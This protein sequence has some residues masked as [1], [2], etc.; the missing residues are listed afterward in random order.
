MEVVMMIAEC[1]NVKP[2]KYKFISGR[3]GSAKRRIPDISTLR[4]YYPEY[5]PRDLRSGLIDIIS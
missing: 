4:K 1:L 5:N 3:K 2:N